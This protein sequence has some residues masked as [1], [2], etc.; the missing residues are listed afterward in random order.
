[1]ASIDGEAYKVAANGL[2]LLTAGAS[3]AENEQVRTA[4]GSR[5]VLRLRDGSLVEVAERSD[6]RVSEGWRRK[7]VSLERG[8]VMVEAA[9]QRQGTLDISTPD[10]LVSVKGTIFGV[11][12]GLKGSRVSVV[13]GEVRVD[14][15]TGIVLLHRG[16]QTATNPTMAPTSVA[17]DISWSANSDKY[18]SLLGELAAI[19][20]KI[21][22][23]PSPRC[24][25]AQ[26]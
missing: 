11:S 8:S 22:A 20:K 5:A 4:K 26:S 21:D 3:I 1:V 23:I 12:R 13:E 15:S 24:A 19:Q 25:T 14:E 18:L 2:T 10:C 17:E 9:K 7:L 6:L 16:D